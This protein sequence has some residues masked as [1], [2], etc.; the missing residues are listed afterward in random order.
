MT[1]KETLGEPSGSRKHKGDVMTPSNKTIIRKN[2]SHGLL[3]LQTIF[4]LLLLYP[5]L[6]TQPARAADA[7]L[8]PEQTLQRFQISDLQLSPNER[9]IAMSVTEPVKDT[10][11][12]SN[13]W[14]YDVESKSLRHFTTS[15]KSDRHPRWSPD[16]TRL[17]F[18]S[19]R[20]GT[21]QIYLMYSSGG[22]GEALTDSKTSINSFEWSPD[23][24]KIAFLASDPKSDEEKAQEKVS[25]VIDKDSNSPR[26]RVIDVKTKK[27][28]ALT[29]ESLR[30]SEFLWLPAGDRLV[31]SA[32]DNPRR[33]L[34]S[35]RLYSLNLSNQ[36]LQDM[37]T[38]EGPFGR[39][40]LSEDGKTL[41]YIGARSA[42]GP[43]PYDL[44]V[45]PLQGGP[46]RN[47]T[48]TSID[49]PIR[50]FERT[51]D[52]HFLV[53]ALTGFKTT[54]YDVSESGQSQ[55]L[56]GFEVNPGS[57]FVVGK[58]LLAFVGET[59]TQAPEL[60]V[61]VNSGRAE[62]V[63]HFNRAWDSIP[64]V[65]PE[66]IHYSSFDG[67]KIEAALIT[68][69]GY[70]RGQQIPFIVL[71]HGGPAGRFDDGFQSWSQLLVAR[72]YGVLLPNI[73]GSI[74]YGHDFQTVNRYDWGG[75]DWKDVMAGADYVVEQGI[76]DPERMGIGG[77]SYGGYMAA[78]AVTQTNR[79]KA[80][81]SGAP[82]TNLFSEFGTESPGVN[83]GDTWALGTPYENPDLFMSRSPV[84]YVKNVK[85]PT[86]ILNGEEDTTDP[87]GQAQ[88]FYRGLQRYGANAELVAYPGMGHGP[89]VE[90]QQ[91]DVMH[92]MLDW[93]EKYVK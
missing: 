1:V 7:P 33:D 85:T 14:V 39:L 56:D 61:S 86:L 17:A 21:T 12:T 79:F 90:K 27:V 93:F 4:S 26:L 25:V 48:A 72:G 34:R 31:L 57:S 13:I 3:T 63:T 32:T 69:A 92:R 91:L 77:W 75:D 18:L 42:D 78:W 58:K 64:L 51:Q 59:T 40:K 47:L 84:T 16:G 49:R 52:G 29:P 28:E 22:E 11:R 71:V 65:A 62:Q 82:M 55:P 53:S 38:P 37:D 6:L 54:L 50:S 9:F 43:G 66:I 2:R 5:A 15:E 74:G 73:R 81:V 76:A 45:R 46:V 88:E 30:I 67:K 87:Y 19:S 83:V 44:V 68:P 60:W 20:E 36:G 80:S 89:R 23:G 35:N 8:T 10:S 24:S 41:F 70:R